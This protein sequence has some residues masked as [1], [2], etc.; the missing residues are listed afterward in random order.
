MSSQV[1]LNKNVTIGIIVGAVLIVL[2][3]I[4]LRPSDHDKIRKAYEGLDDTHI[5]ESVSYSEFQKLGDKESGIYLAVVSRPTCLACQEQL[6]YIDKAV[7]S[8]I[9]DGTIDVDVIYYL[10]TD[11]MKDSDKNSLISNY[12]IKGSTPDLLIMRDNTLVKSSVNWNDEV[13]GGNWSYDSSGNVD[14]Y[15]TYRNFIKKFA[16]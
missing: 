5:F 9:E 15:R 12:G 8:R 3:I 4:F 11:E 7:K 10:N 13:E 2:G 6:P 1:K 14:Y 16:V